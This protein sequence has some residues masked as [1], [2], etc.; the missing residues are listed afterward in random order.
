M[1]NDAVLPLTVEEIRAGGTPAGRLELWGGVECTINRVGDTF[2]S[3]LERAGHVNRAGDLALFSSLGIRALRYPVLWEATAP[4]GAGCA[5]WRFADERLGELQRL[6]IRPIVGLVHHGSGPRHTHLLDPAFATG[7]ARFA[8]AVAE[9]FPWVDDWTPVNEPLTTAR[10][11]AL[12]GLWYPHARDDRSFVLALLN[13]CRAT[14]LA[15]QAIR[16]VNPRARLVQTD[17]L[18]RTYGTAQVAAAVDFYNERRWLAWDLLCGRVAPGKP[19]WTYLVAH[20]A[21]ADELHWFAEQGCRPDIIGV[22]YYVNGE[23]WLDHRLDRYPARLHGGPADGRFADIESV[24]A[25]ATPGPGIAPLIAEV[26][27]RYGLPVAITE[28]HIDARREDQLHWLLDIWRAAEGLRADGID[29]RAVT[30]WSLL[31]AFDW[32]TLVCEGSAHYEP[33]AFDIRAP[34]PRPTAVAVLARQLA[35]GAAPTHPVLQGEGWWRRPDRFSC[36]P[37]ATPTTVT[38]L[39]LHRP[40]VA[41]DRRTPIL[42]SGGSGTLGRSFAAICSRRGIAFRLLGRAT[43]DIADPSSVNTALERWRPWAIVNASGYVRIDAAEAE[44]DRCF[45]ENA[46]GP[47]VLAEQCAAAG[48]ALVTFSSDQVFDGSIA[49]PRTESDPVRPLN[50]YGRSKAK[51]EA[52]VRQAHSGALIIRTSAFFGP[53]DE[54]NFLVHALRALG[55]GEPFT[56]ADDVR[57]SPTYMPDL[58][59]TCLDLLIDGESGVW[60]LANAGDVSWAEFA[61]Q[62]AACAGIGA[63][64]LIRGSGPLPGQ[65]AERPAYAVLGSERGW[66]MPPLH[67]ALVRFVAARPDLGRGHATDRTMARHG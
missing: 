58:V 20:G 47:Q 12:Y 42:I 34:A 51:A 4:D 18:S 13:Q 19:M 64:R 67:D 21:T 40:Q 24:R 62:A 6:G 2:F 23:R 41:A 22:N 43:M 39:H 35:T 7:L 54:H 48:I 55:Q 27:E 59:D 37:V 60:H 36:V 61:A 26:W 66:L 63:H 32:N 45:R 49:R 11:S 14:V 57:V 46:L 31:G 15:M 8:G 53:W 10:F 1:M 28:A 16:R 56:A 38:P 52:R 33:G 30:T 5:D 25:L 29:L 9:R 44:D 50:V 3:Q 17:D 65:I